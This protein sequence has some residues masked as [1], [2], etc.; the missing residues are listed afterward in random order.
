MKFQAGVRILVFSD[1]CHS[2]T[3]LRMKKAD[4][5]N[6]PPTRVRELDEKWRVLRVPLK[7]ER[8]RI[9][10]LPEMREAIGKRPDLRDRIR[11]LPPS[12]PKP[13]EGAT[14]TPPGDEA[15]HVFV[16][17]SMPPGISVKTYQEHRTHYQQL[18]KV[19]PKEGSQV[20]ASV[21]L[22]SGCEDAQTS[23]EI[24]MNG[25]FT[26]M[27]KKVWDNGAFTGDH[28]KFHEDIRKS[29]KQ[30]N[31]DKEP[32]FFPIG[33]APDAFIRQQPYKVEQ[34]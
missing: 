31:P 3:V 26:Y 1:S 9:L 21:I 5:E 12:A 28:Q 2:G 27:L 14:P 19:A 6:P 8:A 10:A 20:K 29:V 17:R 18:G 11:S 7:L 30:E 16:S 32:Y 22:I 13:D 23:A 34:P 15:E 33:T 24:G 25:L 4:M